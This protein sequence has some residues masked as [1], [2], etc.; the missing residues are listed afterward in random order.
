MAQ[1]PRAEDSMRWK[2]IVLIAAVF[3]AG[4]ISGRL[5][6][7]E[8][9]GG[10]ATTTVTEMA[11]AGLAPCLPHGITGSQCA[12]CNPD[13]IAHFKAIGDWCAGHNV[14]E[15]QCELCNFGAVHGAQSVCEP[16]GIA[17]SQCARCN[18]E[19]IAHFKAIGD[20]CAGHNVPESQCE[21]CNFGAVHTTGAG[22]AQKQPEH[23]PAQRATATP[24]PGIAVSYTTAEPVCPTDG[25]VIQFASVETSERAGI[26][27][28]RVMTAPLSRPFEA[29]AEV[30]FDQAAT[31]YMSS[32]LPVT[33][34]QWLVEP[35]DFVPK[36]TPL[37]QVESP[38]MAA[39]QGE[40]LEAWSDWR[41]HQ[42]ERDR[43][44]AMMGRGLIDSASYERTIADAISSEGR[45]IRRQS[46]LRLA[47]MAEVDLDVLRDHR[48]VSSTFLL[49]APVAGTLLDR[50]SNLGSMIE[51]GVRLVTIGDADALW[52]EASVRERDLDRVHLGQHVVFHPDA[53]NSEPIAG[54]VIWVSQFLDPPHPDRHRAHETASRVEANSR[55]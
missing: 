44:E 45:Y 11:G 37:A 14:P 50:P 28:Q 18:P 33:I 41:V 34:R 52:I 42:R 29:P 3:A 6:W 13:L 32:T 36:G 8:H 48:L 12:R 20:W 15:S 31:T 25:A 2:L 17:A 26:V 21:L 53:G 47:G 38:D 46:E 30:V 27:V 39:L 23:D 7:S 19:M 24:Y 5:L 4:T 9:S 55:A 54:E 43:A 22:L 1:K 16:H 40:F 51:P 35:G 10:S 49:R